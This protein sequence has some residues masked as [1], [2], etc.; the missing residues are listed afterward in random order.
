MINLIPPAG[1]RVLKR[2][3]LLRVG[4]T[5]GFIIGVVFLLLTA[6]LVPTYVLTRAQIQEYQTRMKGV[7]NEAQAFADAEKEAEKTQILL[8]QLQT[9]PSTFRAS[10]VVREVER[11]APH[12]IV[13]KTFSILSTAG[14]AKTIQV[15]GTAS[16]REVLIQF[17]KAIEASD[18]FEKAEIPIADFA[19][20]V[21]LPF[22]VTISFS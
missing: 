8:A 9:N 4:A 12:G 11:V 20:D 21:D 16:T 22:T 18:V 10:D 1:V 13:F 7:G 15:Q 5:C 14:V 2:E 19:K 3:Y 17:K 6:T